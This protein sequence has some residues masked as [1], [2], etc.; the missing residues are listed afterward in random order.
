MT[1]ISDQQGVTLIEVM[2]ALVVL[3]ILLSTAVPALGRLRADNQLVAVLNLFSGSMQLARSQAV[4]RSVRTVLCPSD[5][6]S[7]CADVPYWEL[8]WIG[9]ED[10]SGSG[11]CGAPLGADRCDDGGRLFLVQSALDNSV[12]LRANSHLRKAVVFDPQG[13][14]RGAAATFTVCDNRGIDAARGW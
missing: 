7:A 4:T 1:R 9:F 3:A 11:D 6:G 5:N 8:G 14:A 2:T 12:T 13:F 10:P